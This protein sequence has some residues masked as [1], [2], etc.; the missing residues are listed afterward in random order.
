MSDYRGT[1]KHAVHV[2]CKSQIHT[3]RVASAEGI[4]RVPHTPISCE[5][6]WIL[7][8]S[9]AL[10]RTR[11]SVWGC[12]QEIR[13]SREERARCGAPVDSSLV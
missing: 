4:G 10:R 12:V 13:A 9:C 5:V 3:T 8:A 6:S 1:I 11:G 2:S 7:Q